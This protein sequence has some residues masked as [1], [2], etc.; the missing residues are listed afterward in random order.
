MLIYPDSI[1]FK[2]ATRK[3][4]FKLNK[5]KNTVYYSRR[6]YFDT[7]G[8]RAVVQLTSRYRNKFFT[9]LRK[10]LHFNLSVGRVSF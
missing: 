6:V 2:L 5:Y 10:N 4:I 8:S 7:S 3:Y 9:F 1:K